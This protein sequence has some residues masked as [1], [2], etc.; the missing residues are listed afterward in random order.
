MME[1]FCDQESC[2]HHYCG[3]CKAPNGISLTSYSEYPDDME[4]N[5]FE[6]SLKPTTKVWE[7]GVRKHDQY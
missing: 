3:D 4:C 5:T 7:L 6:V 1:I 2:V